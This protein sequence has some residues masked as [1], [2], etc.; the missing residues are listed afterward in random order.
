MVFIGQE[1][2]KRKMP[3]I[4]FSANAKQSGPTVLI[5]GKK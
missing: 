4:K 1:K 5:I 3:T 2:Y